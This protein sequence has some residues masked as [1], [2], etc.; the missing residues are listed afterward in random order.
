MQILG[1]EAG[2]SERDVKS[3]YRKLS[4]TY[5]PDKPGGNAELFQKIA[6][7][8]EALMD[9]E[10]RSNWEKYGN[11]DGK[12]AL[13]VGIGI[14]S[15]LLDESFKHLFLGG[16]LLMLVAAI[17]AGLWYCTRT[18]TD[19]KHMGVEKRTIPWLTKRV[20]PDMPPPVLPETLAGA[21]EMAPKSADFPKEAQEE[22]AALREQ[23]MKP[24]GSKTSRIVETELVVPEKDRERR[25]QLPP[26]AFHP[27][28]VRINNIVIHAV[29]SRLPLTT[30]F[31]KELAARAAAT[32]EPLTRVAALYCMEMT[33]KNQME[34]GRD[35]KAKQVSYLESA[36]SVHE[37]A[38]LFTQALYFKD[39][40][41]R[42][43]FTPAQ[44]E[45]LRHTAARVVSLRGVDSLLR[46]LQLS[47]EERAVALQ[48]FPENERKEVEAVLPCFPEL[49]VEVQYEVAGE[50][51]IAED[52]IITANIFMHHRNLSDKKERAAALVAAK[53]AAR[54]DQDAITQMLTMRADKL[55]GRPVDEAEYATLR[56]KYG[57]LKRVPE[58]DEL[59]RKHRK[60]NP[61]AKEPVP[62]VYAPLF[63]ELRQE[64]W[65][66]YI[67]DETQKVL[68]NT[69]VTPVSPALALHACCLRI[70]CPPCCCRCCRHI[71]C[72][73]C[74]Y[75]FYAFHTVQATN[76][77]IEMVRFL[78]PRAGR[79][80][81]TL[82]LRSSCYLG[83]DQEIG[84]NV[85]VRKKE[86]VA[87]K[88]VEKGEK[89][90][91]VPSMETL[92]GFS[93]PRDDSD[94]SD[95]ED[96]A[97]RAGPRAGATAGAA[98]GA[99]ADSDKEDGEGAGAGAGATAGAGAG[100][101][102]SKK[103]A[104][105]KAAAAAAAEVDEDD[106]VLEAAAAAA[107]AE[108]KTD[109]E[110]AEALQRELQKRKAAEKA[111]AKEEEEDEEDYGSI[112]VGGKKAGD[113][114]K[115]K[116][117]KGGKNKGK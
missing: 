93:G 2:S 52:D 5:H 30:A 6:K 65:H 103:A 106:K 86:D 37:F 63:P 85:D 92:L 36:F 14:P 74:V 108:A 49:E 80:R 105:K 76:E 56:E 3:A 66:L 46:F 64:E 101:L 43:I 9:P 62:T 100:R 78:A 114:G 71:Q 88:A 32:L 55:R 69:V 58:E 21:F 13:E 99:D 95:S 102:Q 23:L 42:Q 19:T 113:G 115:G 47:D 50:A 20:V 51:F 28:A 111:K 31:T 83:L 12:Q 110:E 97:P 107:A 1:L 81:F 90:T 15:I 38:A 53:A 73:Y 112:V 39:S 35:P 40:S 96:E 7:A 33:I 82:H 91:A 98:A 44:L 77:V 84:V 48:D 54:A 117:G 25:P 109:K 41:L 87:V 70:E 27:D 104:A 68:C 29:M 61:K 75:V 22:V 26:L 89:D 24:V 94:T 116:K 10:A 11:P 18:S 59:I 60:E 16:Y 67:T 45:R 8:Y 17:P 57:D 34:R 4:L 72:A 79:H